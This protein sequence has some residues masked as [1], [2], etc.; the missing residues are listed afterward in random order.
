MFVLEPH[1]VNLDQKEAILDPGNVL[2]IACPGSGK[3]RALTY[4][5][6]YELSILN[7][8]KKYIIAI[9]YT[10]KAADE[11][12]ERIELLGI[13]TS[14]LWIGTI[15]AF[16]T[17]WILRPY[18]IH[19]DELK[20]GF[21]IINA[22]ETEE[23]LIDFCAPYIDKRITVFD[24]AHIFTSTGCQLTSS[25]VS[26]HTYV[27]EVLK[28]YWKHL[29]ENHQVDFELILYYSYK[30]ISDF[31]FIAKNLAN[32]FTYI[33]VD[34]FQDTREIQYEILAAIL[35]ASSGGVR[36]FIV[37]DPNQAIYTSL[38]GYP[39]KKDKLEMTT[40]YKFKELS[41]SGNYRS[42]NIIINYFDYY[43]TYHNQIVGCGVLK[44]YPSIVSHNT[45]VSRNSLEDEIVRLILYNIN[46]KGI[47][48]EEICIIAPQWVHLAGLTRNLMVKL[49][50]YSFNGPG[51]APF[52]RDIDN[53]FYKLSRIILTEP[54]PNLYIRRLRWS[55]EVLHDLQHAGVNLLEIDRKKFLK[56]CNSINIDQD[57]GIEYLKEFIQALFNEIGLEISSFQSLKE[58]YDSFFKASEERIARLKKDGGE[59]ISTTE[60]FR[61][62]FKQHKGITISTIH[63]VKGGE[64]DTVISFALLEGYVPHF[65]DQDDDAAKKLLYVICSRAKKNLHL[66][67]ERERFNNRNPPQEY[68][69]TFRLAQ[70]LYDYQEI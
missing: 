42:S 63:G 40:G 67:S 16:C 5:L 28:T 48:P 52:A 2:L 11:I 22:H 54:S 10:H 41:L 57:Q 38:G 20:H 27:T 49:P 62:V 65:A 9:T 14:Q 58:H 61:K 18:Y 13:D 35:R 34:E 12:K 8:D 47:R 15:H 70:Y 25:Y 59:F 53:F 64:Y 44:D 33:L 21:R 69:T 17:E 23:L 68:G 50:D 3:T 29:K 36:T 39:I 6:A 26:K 19:L 24:C 4:K 46:N 32:I 60:N 56:I 1:D 55:S 45:D 37:G 66:I 51:M 30:L 7:S 31:G 43:K